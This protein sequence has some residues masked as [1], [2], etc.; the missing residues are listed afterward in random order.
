MEMFVIGLVKKLTEESRNWRRKTVIV[1]DGA[2]YHRSD[3]T[4]KLLK[5]LDVPL[6]I[7]GPHSYDASPCELWFAHFKKADI[8]PRKVK[9]N[10]R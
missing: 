10:K 5:D 7:T 4:L 2:A 9:T 6:M 3:Q 1:W 8:N